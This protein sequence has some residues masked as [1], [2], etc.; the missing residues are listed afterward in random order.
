MKTGFGHYLHLL[1]LRKNANR[2]LSDFNWKFALGDFPEA[3]K[4]DFNDANWRSLNVPHDF[5]I[6]HPFDSTNVTNI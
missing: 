6:E 4:T 2:Q 5:S 1:E 3:S